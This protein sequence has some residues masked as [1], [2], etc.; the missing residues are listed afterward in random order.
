MSI[1][2]EQPP[3]L[4]VFHNGETSF[5]FDGEKKIL[6]CVAS[7][8]P[9]VEKGDEISRDDFNEDAFELYQFD[10]ISKDEEN[11]QE[12]VEV[13]DEHQ[14][15]IYPEDLIGCSAFFIERGSGWVFTEQEIGDLYLAT[16]GNYGHSTNTLDEM[17]DWICQ[18]IFAE[19]KGAKCGL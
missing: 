13:T 19:Q 11:F 6:T 17:V 8:D 4:Q 18:E 14:F 16:V 3:T 15:H 9:A 1:D 12:V 7:R 10:R 5:L 2:H